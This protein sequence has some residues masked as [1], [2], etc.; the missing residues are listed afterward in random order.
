LIGRKIIN[1]GGEV[2]FGEN[3]WVFCSCGGWLHKYPCKKLEEMTKE[4]A[5]RRWEERWNVNGNEELKKLKN[6]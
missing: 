2:T 5:F 6:F 4:E 3:D 1:I